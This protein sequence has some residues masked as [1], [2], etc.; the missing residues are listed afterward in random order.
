[1]LL[2]DAS[3]EWAYPT[4]LSYTGWTYGSDTAKIPDQGEDGH[5]KVSHVPW[6]AMLREG[7]FKYIR[8][9]VAGEREELYDLQADPAELTNLAGRTEHAGRVLSMRGEA[10]AQ[11]RRTEA[12][13]VDTLPPV[14]PLR[15]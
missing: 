5:S 6:Y 4:L 14:R 9:Y 3:A 8:T 13:F 1:M 7:D 15:P 12:P 10:I 2:S 11:L